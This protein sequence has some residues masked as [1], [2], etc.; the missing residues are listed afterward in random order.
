MLK[1]GKIKKVTP[2]ETQSLQKFKDPS[3]IVAVDIVKFTEIQLKSW[4][5]MLYFARNSF[6]STT[7]WIA[8]SELKELSGY[9]RHDDKYLQDSITDFCKTAVKFNMLGKSKKDHGGIVTTLLAG[10]NFEKRPGWVEFQFSEMLKEIVVNSKMFSNLSLALVRNL[11]TKSGLALY[12]ILNDYKGINYTPAIPIETLRGLLG[13]AEG[14]YSQFKDFNKRILSR[15]CQ[16]VKDKT[17]LEATPHF[18]R[19]VRKVSAVKFEIKEQSSPLLVKPKPISAQKK[20]KTAQKNSNNPYGHLTEVEARSALKRLVD[21]E[22]D[23][24][25]FSSDHQKRKALL[26]ERIK[27]L[28]VMV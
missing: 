12:R 5:A 21:K 11:E 28:G 1:M 14:E 3:E 9:G 4:L 27:A 2:T 26:K 20:D 15:A 24:K 19:T 18:I 6:S 16:Q 22:Y 25:E 10:A 7:H 13:V 8:I 17:D 23:S